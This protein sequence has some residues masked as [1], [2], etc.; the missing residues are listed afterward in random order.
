MALIVTE[1]L[2]K[3]Y[4]LGPHTVHALRGVTVE[5]ERGEFVA[6]MGPSGSG[7]STF[8]NILGCLDSPTT[9]RYVLDGEDV[10]GLAR[11]AL[12]RIRNHKIGFVFQTFNLLPRT[13]ALEN[14]ELPLLYA[15]LPARERRARARE[16]LAAVGL[17][18]RATHHPSQL[19][20]GQ[21]Q[22]VAIARALVNDPAVLL[23]DEPTGNLDTRTSAEILA[24]M[25]HLNRQGITIV[26]VTHEPDIAAYA[27]RVLTFRD[28]R[29]LRDD[30]VPSPR[31]ATAALALLEEEVMA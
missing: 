17:A 30:P 23:A 5:V 24:L 12:A 28:G 19:S 15:G 1:E 22:R 31:D 9:G 20:G 3:D 27:R 26:L 6:V 10:A 25:Q 2:T 29:L 8:M 7:K 14:V 13:S 4:R 21:Q 16:R 18:D 11:D